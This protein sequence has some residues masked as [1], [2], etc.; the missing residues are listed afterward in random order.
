MLHSHSITVRLCSPGQSN[1]RNE[2]SYHSMHMLQRSK[3]HQNITLEVQIVLIYNIHNVMG[4]VSY[5]N[6]DITV[7]T[8]HLDAFRMIFILW[9]VLCT[10]G[11]CKVGSRY[12]V[13]HSIVD[14][15]HLIHVISSYKPC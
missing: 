15:T 7:I 13:M 5:H 2:P 12:N 3:K 4:I 9:A 1:E 10:F 11:K 14:T 8:S 6:V